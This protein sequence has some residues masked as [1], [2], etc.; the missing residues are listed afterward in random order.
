MKIL[1]INCGS[2]SLKY[3]LLEMLGEHRLASG[4]VERIGESMGKVSHQNRPDAAGGQGIVYEKPISDHRSA[5][6]EAVGQLTAPGTGVISGPSEIAAVGHRVVHGGELFQEPVQVDRRVLE[7]IQKTIPLAP[8]HNPANLMGIKVARELFPH[9]P[10][11]AVF[12][13]AF[14]QTIPAFAYHYALP[15]SYY[16]QMGVRR[17]GFHGTSHQYVA[18]EA[19]IRLGRPPSAVNLI[20]AHLGS[21]ASICAIEKGVSVDTSMGMT[22]LG[23]LIMGTRGGNLDP[24]VVMYIAERKG[25]TLEEVNAVLQKES[26]LKGICGM[27]DLRDI[28]AAAGD[29][30]ARA[31]LALDMFVYRCRQYIGAYFFQLG[32]VDA[33]VFTAGVGENDAVIRE[34]CC[35]GMATAGLTLDPQKN[36]YPDRH[37]G[38]I[39]AAGSRI[40]GYVIP[41][42][43]ELEIARQTLGVVEGKE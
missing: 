26:G 31:Q 35:R 14:H 29:G 2:S 25:M 24:G 18:R 20:T 42:N 36:R 8:L 21:G 28:H 16:E 17:Y 22:P 10:Q 32:R 40:K 39:T 19:A 7:A 6:N 38:E 23:G 27:N 4:L 9:A 34:A 1:V 30:N 33:L 43:E 11:V 41:T 15:W 5:M 12:D 37:G 3:Q 13:T